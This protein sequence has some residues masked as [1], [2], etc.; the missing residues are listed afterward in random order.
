MDHPVSQAHFDGQILLHVDGVRVW[1]HLLSLFYARD[2]LLLLDLNRYIQQ[3]LSE[4]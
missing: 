2:D 1:R 4:P 3:H